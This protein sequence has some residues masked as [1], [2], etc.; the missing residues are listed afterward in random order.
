MPEY[1]HLKTIS[2]PTF[3]DNDPLNQQKNNNR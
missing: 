3:V 1:N 2:V